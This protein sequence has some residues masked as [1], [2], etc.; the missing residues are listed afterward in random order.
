MKTGRFVIAAA[1][2]VAALA[3]PVLIGGAEKE[4]VYKEVGTLGSSAATRCGRLATFCLMP[5]GNLIV[6]DQT[7]KAIK[8]ITPGDKLVST[9]KLDFIPQAV[10]AASD[11]L[12]YVGG[13]GKVAKVDETGK[14]AKTLDTATLALPRSYITSITSTDKQLFVAMRGKAGYSVYRFGHDLGAGKEIITRLRGCCGQMDVTAH[15]GNLWVAEN[16]RHRVVKY[17]LDGKQLAA[18]GKRDRTGK[19]GFSGCCN[20]MNLCIG[21]GGAVYTAE[22]G[23]SVIK[24]FTPGGEF[25]GVVAQTTAGKACK[26]VRLAVNADGSRVYVVDVNNNVIRVLVGP[27]VERPLAKSAGKRAKGK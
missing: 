15:G 26:H 17:D 18:W 1:V 12:V 9:L 19:N 5:N 2:I 3:F 20:P 11:T 23:L 14:V 24:R 6:C 21:P 27:K 13:H 25:L 16:G 22:S 8:I 4:P 7:K 10:H